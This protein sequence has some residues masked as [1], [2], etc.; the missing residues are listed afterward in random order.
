MNIIEA[1]NNA[2]LFK[3]IFKDLKT[4]RSWLVLLKALFALQ[5][6]AKELS[7]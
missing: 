7:L 6:D 1:I 2:K 3:P 4:W 5:M